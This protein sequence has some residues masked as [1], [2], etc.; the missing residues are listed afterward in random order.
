MLV[1]LN[2]PKGSAGIAGKRIHGYTESF[3]PTHVTRKD[4]NGN[5]ATLVEAPFTPEYLE[6][7]FKKPLPVN[8]RFTLSELYYIDYRVLQQLGTYLGIDSKLPRLNLAKKIFLAL[9]DA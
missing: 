3:P 6:H 2:V 9:K 1:Y 4:Y 7:I 5:K 8:V